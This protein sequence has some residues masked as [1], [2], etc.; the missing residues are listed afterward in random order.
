MSE[1]TSIYR[2]DKFIV[3]QAAREE[4]L[5]KVHDTHSVLRHQ[6]GFIR[7]TILEQVAGPG[8]VLRRI[9]QTTRPSAPDNSCQA[10]L[11]LTRCFA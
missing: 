5:K 2:V 7:D 11:T 6:P 9:L 4:F 10:M 8:W 3:P 1:K